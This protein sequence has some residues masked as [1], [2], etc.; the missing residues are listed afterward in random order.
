M[1]KEFLERSIEVLKPGGRLVVI[2]YHSLEDRIVKDFFRS[3][4]ITQLSPKEDPFGLKT[5]PARLKVIT[6]KP[7]LPTKEEIDI[8]RR[9]RSAKLRAAERI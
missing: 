6:K 5:K 8:N 4:S 1:L 2:S 7:I 3:E 9:A